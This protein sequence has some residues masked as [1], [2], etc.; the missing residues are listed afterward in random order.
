MSTQSIYARAAHALAAEL[1]LK[2][3]AS[4]G[5]DVYLLII[6]RY[7]RLFAY[8][9][10]AL[11][12]ALYFEAL[13]FSDE[14]IGLFMTLTLLGDVVISLLLT[15]LADSLGRRRTLL[16]GSLM[17]AVSGVVFATTSNYIALLAAAIIGVISPS[18]NEIGPF[19]AV[20]ESTLAHLIPESARPDVFAWYVVLAVMG[21]STGLLVG[22]IAVDRFQVIEGWSDVDAYR[23]IFWIYSGVACLKALMT[24]LLSRECEQDSENP[25]QGEA[26]MQP[27]DEREPLLNDNGSTVQR[28]R[29]DVQSPKRRNPFTA[30]SKPSRWIL[31]KLCSLFFFDSLGSGM[32]PFSLVNLYIERKFNLPKNKLGAI[33]SAT[34][35]V[36]TIGNI[37]A[38]SL[39]KRI[40]LIPAMVA[41]HL[42]SS[43]FLGLLPVPRTLSWTI[44]LLVGRACLNS[45][46]Q[47]PRSAFLSLVVLPE[48]RTA[49]MGIVNI[50][51]TLSQSSGPAVT[52]VLAGHD[53]FWVAFVS[54][55]S[56]KAV[57]DLGLLAFFPSNLRA[58][59]KTGA[60]EDVQ[61]G[62]GIGGVSTSP[63]TETPRDDA[64][65]G[66][67]KATSA[68]ED[69]EVVVQALPPSGSSSHG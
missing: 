9:A 61:G 67:S 3:I 34:W 54:A 65:S 27:S 30:I 35:F 49:V 57:Y 33:M 36:S 32:V 47:A 28:P 56:L 53:H 2:T 22:G 69:D 8:G 48:E 37:F 44:C 15:F 10:V 43:I 12:I 39:A 55:G 1:G 6:A 31:L 26:R 58:P 42:P 51:K 24:L 5:K 18:G 20:E 29:S 60:S 62:R 23:M 16:L 40:G 19:R 66:S 64:E 25:S 11:I 46:D 21:T 45:M 14:H 63:G 50:L 7:L 59:G 38:A 17:M 68:D 13:G 52:G 4:A 41:T